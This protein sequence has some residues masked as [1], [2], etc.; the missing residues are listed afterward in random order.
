MLNESV[1]KAEAY[2]DRTA[3]DYDKPTLNEVYSYDELYDYVIDRIEWHYLEQYLPKN[4]AVLDAAGGT[5]RLAIPIALKGLNVTI[6]DVS[7]GMLNVAKEKI[8]KAGLEN[9]ITL[10]KGD[11]HQIDYPD[12][13]FDFAFAMGIEYCYDLEK[14]ISELTRVLK[15]GCHLEFSVDSLFFVVWAFL[16]ERN[17]EGALKVLHERKYIDEDDVYCWVYTPTQ[18]RRMCE[19]KGLQ[20]EKIVGGGICTLIKDAKYREEIFENKKEL[21]KL[22]KIEFKLCE[23]QDT[24]I[25]ANHPIVI[26]KKLQNQYP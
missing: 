12:D 13:S 3:L 11:I 26:A 14:V 9:R 21:E 18:L 16:N 8:K 24:A 25:L 4:G 7:E 6:L 1:S 15:P 17:L 19:E 10:K 22:L 2:F 5:G 20:V 23:I